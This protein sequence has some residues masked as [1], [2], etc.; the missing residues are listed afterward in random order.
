MGDVQIKLVILAETSVKGGG[1]QKT[2]PLFIFGFNI[3]S[4]D[5]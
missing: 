2:L 3:M 5:L 4:S 1:D